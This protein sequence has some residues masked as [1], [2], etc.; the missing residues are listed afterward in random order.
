MRSNQM[1]LG[2]PY[3]YKIKNKQHI[4]IDKPLNYG[5]LRIEYGGDLSTLWELA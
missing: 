5:V 2:V 4:N 1:V 3:F